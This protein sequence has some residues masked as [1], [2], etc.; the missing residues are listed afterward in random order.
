VSVNFPVTG[1]KGPD[2]ELLTYLQYQWGN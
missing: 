2:N 1:L